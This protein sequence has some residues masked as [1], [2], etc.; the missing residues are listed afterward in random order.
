MTSHD[1][2]GF[3]LTER[4]TKVIAC[5]VVW[6]PALMRGS[7]FCLGWARKGCVCLCVCVCVFVCVCVRVRARMCVH[8]C[9]RMCARER[10]CMSVCTR[11]CTHVCAYV[12]ARMPQGRCACSRMRSISRAEAPI[13]ASHR[14][15]LHPHHPSLHQLWI[16]PHCTRITLCFTC[17]TLQ[18][19]RIPPRCL[20][21]LQAQGRVQLRA[22]IQWKARAAGAGP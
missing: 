3:G 1:M 5:A 8:A 2:P 21:C 4:C 9:V 20:V 14:S 11:V 18:C 15:S 6:K 17:I 22:G 7:P 13:Q 12:C 10:V 19:T 16:A